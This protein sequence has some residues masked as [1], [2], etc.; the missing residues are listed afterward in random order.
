[1]NKADRIF[2]KEQGD[3]HLMIC[4]R[5]NSEDIDEE[6]LSTYVKNLILP[7]DILPFVKNIGDKYLVLER[8]N[9]Y[10]LEVV[11]RLC[12]SDELITDEFIVNN[13]N[14][15]TCLL[16]TGINDARLNIGKYAEWSYQKT[17]ARPGG[18]DVAIFKIEK[19]FN[20]EPTMDM[21]AVSGYDFREI[22]SCDKIYKDAREDYE[23]TLEK[24]PSWINRN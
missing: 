17:F 2:S 4:V 13:G 22:Y 11:Q 14:L 15:T 1:M 20:K 23:K 10:D 24:L 3:N 9:N 19:K 5:C 12:T 6:G 7:V 21:H 16:T 18:K 8:N